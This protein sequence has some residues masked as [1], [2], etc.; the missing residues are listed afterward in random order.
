MTFPDGQNPNGFTNHER[1]DQ[2]DHEYGRE[3][4]EAS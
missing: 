2:P 3:E 1:D 4:A